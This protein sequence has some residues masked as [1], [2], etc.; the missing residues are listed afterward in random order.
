MSHPCLILAAGFGTRMGAL[1]ADR[2]KPLIEVAGIPLLDRALSVARDADCT[3][4]AVNAHYRADQIAAHLAGQTDV[5]VLEEHPEILDSGGSVK[6]AAKASGDGPMLTL[7]ADNVWRGPNPLKALTAAFDPATMGALLLLVPRDRAIGRVGVGDFAMDDQ[8]RLTLDKS[9]HS[10]VYLGAQILDP[11]P[12][13]N[14]PRDVFSLHDAWKF[15]GDQGRL[16]GLIY[17]GNWADVGHPEGIARA[18][19]MLERADV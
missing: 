16:Y 11:T 3:P 2:P 1:T 12:C 18:E 4:I 15:Y 14:D 7:N 17:E 5:T 8:G 10:F 13:R 6:N 19:A 9:D